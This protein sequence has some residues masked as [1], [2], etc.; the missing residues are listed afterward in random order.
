M[1]AQD[2][3]ELGT[4]IDAT[5]MQVLFAFLD[6]ESVKKWWG[7]KN[8]I[9][10]P[11]PGG[12]FVVEWE[13]GSQGQDDLLGPL[14]GT[15]VGT[16]DRAMSGHFVYFGNLQWLSPRGEV[17]GPTRL[18]VD[19]FSKND[20]RRKPTMLQVRSTGYEPGERWERY[21][22]LSRRMWEKTLAGLAEFCSRQSP[23][24]AE[25]LVGVL[26]TTYL[27]EAVLQGRRI[28]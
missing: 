4:T 2:S 20:P 21:R 11:R 13:P 9:V 6:P 7:A 23:E 24:Q 22:D 3:F 1:P 18:E 28:S 27:A 25:R 14:G 17:F 19:V 10:Q 8:A 5:A 15:L 16:L 12:L 26:G